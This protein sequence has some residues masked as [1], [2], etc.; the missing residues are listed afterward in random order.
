MGINAE[1]AKLILALKKSRQIG[2]DIL[3]LGRPE[4]FA[5]QIQLAKIVKGFGLNWTKSEL[6][7]IVKSAFAEPF[8][9][10]CGFNTIQSMDFSNYEGADVIHD[11]NLPIHSDLE[12]ISSFVYDGGTL[13]HV[14]D[15]AQAFRN[16]LKLVKIGGTLCLSNPANGQAGHG[17]YQFSPELFFRLLEANGFADIE[18]YLVAM[19]TP[20][21]WFKVADPRTLGRRSQFLTSEAVQIFVVANKQ[22]NYEH[23]TIPQQ[24]D[25]ADLQWNSH[26][27]IKTRANRIWLTRKSKL[28]GVILNRFIYPLL[29]VA[30]HM[31]GVSIPKQGLPG[32]WRRKNF[33][34]VDPYNL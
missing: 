16:V 29:V 3:C 8:L 30:R 23:F 13:E 17:F 19:L 18:I 27:V 32:L 15:V 14:F 25:Y 28:R 31:F 26:T 4:F 11:L 20:A 33:I 34:S 2:D 9:T 21:K 22:K 24:S 7:T 6:E 10:A 1:E 12:D 5:S